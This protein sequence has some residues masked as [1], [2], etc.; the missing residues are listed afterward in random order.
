M[1]E[2]K[3]LLKQ[4]YKL[5]GRTPG[6]FRVR[7]LVTEKAFLGSA[8]DLNGPLNRIRFQL[9]LGNYRNPELQADYKRL[10][11]EAFAFEILDHVEP[12]G[13]SGEDL[14]VELEALEA[15]WAPTLDPANTYNT[16]ERLHFP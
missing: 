15:K 10:G 1:N 3:K 6:I 11:P 14:E 4:Q 2:R 7:N 9:E 13:R 8:L 16:A 12:E 5:E